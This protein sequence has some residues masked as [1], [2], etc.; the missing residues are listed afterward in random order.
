MTSSRRGAWALL[1]GLSLVGAA[2]LGLRPPGAG[3]L[4]PAD[5]PTARLDD[6]VTRQFGMELPVVW[7][8]EGRAGTVWSA[9][10][11]ERLQALTRAVF[12]LSGVIA[13]DVV[14]LA[15]PNL[16]EVRV[17]DGGLT[18]QYLMGEVPRDAGAIATLRERVSDD[19]M[20][21]GALVSLDGRAALVVANF[22]P[23][24]DQ[25]RLARAAL[26]LR[27]RFR[28][29]VI[30]VWTVGAPILAVTAPASVRAHLP[31]IAV[32]L[33][34]LVAAAMALAGVRRVLAG[35][36]AA[37]VG[38][39]TGGAAAA[40]LGASVAWAALAGVSGAALAGTLAALRMPWPLRTAAALA[41]GSATALAVVAATSG[42]SVAPFFGATAAGALVAPF[43]AA[44]ARAAVGPVPTRTWGRWPRHVLAVI[45]LGAALGAARLD[46]RLDAFGYGLRYLPSPAR[47]DLA[48]M[49]RDFPPPV[50]FAVR[51]RGES[52]FVARP[53]VLPAF[54]RVTDAMRGLP[55]VTSATSLADLVK[56]VH[57]A[58]NDDRAEFERLPDEPGLTGR[59]LA[60]AYSPG[61]RRFVDRP[62]AGA[63]I[64]VSVAPP[65][66]GDVTRAHASLVATL[67]AH[68]IP[69]ATV[70]PPSGDAMALLRAGRT[71]TALVRGAVAALLLGALAFVPI[72]GG[73]GA[74]HALV[75]AVAS[76][77]A[78]A[79]ALGWI[80][81][82]LD[83]VSL[84]A[85]VALAL[86]V[87][88]GAAVT[89]A[90]EARSAAIT[91]GRKAS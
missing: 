51:V 83:L 65:A 70:D 58:F 87:L 75:V 38:G 26:A 79:G 21:R 19:P 80:G 90:A 32:G 35:L 76:A 18:P 16:R 63:A 30:E 47:D 48:A 68:P 60:L 74:A 54:E 84:P 25:D 91:A 15:S 9:D 23:D 78:L 24:V 14:S 11:L 45:V 4:A 77:G 82:P 8:V 13:P 55:G 89:G 73:L 42:P 56:R 36:L 5:A 22:R 59:Y 40:A 6:E 53:G 81:I 46:L 72:M 10:V 17:T 37:T 88:L 62:L 41:L 2:V 34:A 43:V 85:L 44:W 28:D 27:D 39:L 69:G 61:F 66:L 64:W 12:A 33:V 20:L 7:I 50:S 86:A 71:V 31:A 67:A 49:A 57:R 3:G 1:V 29:D 52:G